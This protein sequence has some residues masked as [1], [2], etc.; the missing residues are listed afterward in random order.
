MLFRSG[1]HRE[2]SPAEEHGSHAR[3]KATRL[4]GS[5]SSQKQR[6]DLGGQPADHRP[7]AN[8]GFHDEA[9]RPTGV[10]GEEI[11]PRDLVGDKQD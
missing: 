3:R 10:D 2:T 7:A 6:P 9:D 1:K 8:F 11:Q 4:A 5:G